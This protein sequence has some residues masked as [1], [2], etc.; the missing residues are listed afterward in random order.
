VWAQTGEVSKQREAKAA[1]DAELRAFKE[2]QMKELEQ[3]RQRLVGT[4]SPS[5]CP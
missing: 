2:D 4:Y 5:L 3:Y 1:R